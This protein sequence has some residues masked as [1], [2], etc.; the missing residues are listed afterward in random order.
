[1]RKG[2][3]G[4]LSVAVRELRHKAKEMTR[5]ALV[6]DIGASRTRRGGRLEDLSAD[7]YP[8]LASERGQSVARAAV[9]MRSLTG[10]PL[11]A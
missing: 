10:W 6:V 7:G 11:T 2:Y 3:L 4:M 1:M 9:T 8:A 5:Y